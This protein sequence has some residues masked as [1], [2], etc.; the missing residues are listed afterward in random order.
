ME[1]EY[2]LDLEHGGGMFGNLSAKTHTIVLRKEF[3]QN[4]ESQVLLNHIH[5]VHNPG[6]HKAVYMKLRLVN[7]IFI[8]IHIY[9]YTCHVCNSHIIFY[10]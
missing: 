10:V 2:I 6:Y 4:R 7:Y 3:R 8:L 1:Y 5:F 9:R